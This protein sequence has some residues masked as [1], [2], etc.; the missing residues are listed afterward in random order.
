MNIIFDCK[1][2]FSSFD[3]QMNEIFSWAPA[4]L[5]ADTMSLCLVGKLDLLGTVKIQSMNLWLMHECDI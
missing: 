4:E 3:F 5:L 1:C 2:L